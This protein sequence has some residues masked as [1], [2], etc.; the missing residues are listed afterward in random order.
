MYL[1]IHYDNI[2]ALLKVFI[3]VFVE[4][5]GHTTF[6]WLFTNGALPVKK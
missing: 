1:K 2:M 5:I 4:V 6:R 3:S